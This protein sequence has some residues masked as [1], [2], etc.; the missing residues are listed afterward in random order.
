MKLI[1]FLYVFTPKSVYKYPKANNDASRN[2]FRDF[3]NSK[4]ISRETTLKPRIIHVA[5]EI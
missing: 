2:N 1:A 4:N 5:I 3:E